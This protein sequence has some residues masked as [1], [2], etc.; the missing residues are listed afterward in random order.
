MVDPDAPNPSE[1]TLREYLHWLVTDIPGTTDSNFVN[2]VELYDSPR[3]TTGIHR[4]VF[5]LFKQLGHG[6]VE[7]QPNQWRQ[8][9]CTREFAI[10]YNLGLP[11]AV[12][13]FNCQRES[14]FWW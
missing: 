8:N 6:T 3:P 2:V 13:Y 9:F 10:N 5:A 4:F 1:P 11:V 7:P 12:S 14:G